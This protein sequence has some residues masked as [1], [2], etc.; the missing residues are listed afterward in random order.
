MVLYK[1]STLGSFCCSLFINNLSDIGITARVQHYADNKM[2]FYSSSSAAGTAKGLQGDSNVLHGTLQDARASKHMDSLQSEDEMEKFHG[3]SAWRPA[4]RDFF[5]RVSCFSPRTRQPRSR[6][7][8]STLAITAHGLHLPQS[9]RK[10]ALFSLVT[11]EVI[12]TTETALLL[13]KQQ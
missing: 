4:Y 2:L 11:F 3:S 12:L 9:N 1:R 13:P 7:L 10:P 6:L 8:Q 5:T